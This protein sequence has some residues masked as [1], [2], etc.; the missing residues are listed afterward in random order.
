M[1]TFGAAM[2]TQQFDIRWS[3][4]DPNRHVANATYANLM[5]EIR[6][7]FLRENGISQAFFAKHAVGPVIFSEEFYYIKEVMPNARVT[8]GVEL[9]AHTAD[10]RLMKFSQYLFNEQQK[11]SVYSETFFGWMNLDERK[12]IAPPEELFATLDKMSKAPGYHLLPDDYSLKN[13]KI[14]VGRTLEG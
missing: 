11:L 5:T 3:D 9:L 14:P 12:L 8:V 10:A 2:F 1:I 4:L 13:P 7:G 6:L